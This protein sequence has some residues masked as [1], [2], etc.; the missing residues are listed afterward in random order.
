[1]HTHKKALFWYM[2]GFLK[3]NGFL[4]ECLCE[5]SV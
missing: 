5:I 4:L 3:D 1:M 2:Q